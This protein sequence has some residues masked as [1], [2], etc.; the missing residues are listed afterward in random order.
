MD[1]V[2]ARRLTPS[3]LADK[4]ST[5]RDRLD[6]LLDSALIAH[7]GLVVEDGPLVIPTIFARDGDRILLHGSTGSRWL[8]ALAAG[9]PVCV[10]I[11][12]LDGIVVARS[13]FESS[14]R[15]RSACLFGTCTALEAEETARA[16]ALFT[17]AVLPGRAAEIRP[18]TARELAATLVVALP[19][20]QWS[21]K[22][23]DG[24]PEDPEG[25][26]AGEAWAGVVGL[27]TAY[28]QPTPAPD[29]RSG[30]T[31]PESVRRLA[32]R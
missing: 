27:R 22:V 4:A 21:L 25:D 10:T 17:E 26:V 11:T 3:R 16:L 7:V 20:D 28:E 31:V 2:K 18:S 6:E 14:M 12:A 9:A 29:L 19:I 30:I 1:D 5:E 15:Y 24:W 8:R 32:E 13:A 23:S